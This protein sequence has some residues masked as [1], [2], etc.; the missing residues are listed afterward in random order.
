MGTFLIEA[1]ALEATS[2]IST[3]S[4]NSTRGTATGNLHSLGLQVPSTANWDREAAPAQNQIRRAS[5]STTSRSLRLT[6]VPANTP[7]ECVRT[8]TYFP[9][10]IGVLTFQTPSENVFSYF[11]SGFCNVQHSGW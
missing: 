9:V 4:N 5:C 7:A 2:K 1:S 11:I 8:M 3:T 10:S 6:N